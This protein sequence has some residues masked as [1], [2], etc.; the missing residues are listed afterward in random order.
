MINDNIASSLE[1]TILYRPAIFSYN[2]FKR[3]ELPFKKFYYNLRYSEGGFNKIN[4][5]EKNLDSFYLN[6]PDS[7]PS[8]YRRM[9]GE[10]E[11][12]VMNVLASEIDEDT[13]YWEFGGAWGY[14][15]MAI[16][17]NV[18]ECYSFEAMEERVSKINKSI[19]KN[20]YEHVETI[21]GIVGE[22]VKL[23]Q[24]PTPDILLMDV[25]GF[26]YKILNENSWLLEN[27]TTFIIEVHTEEGYVQSAGETPNLNPEGVIE[28]LKNNDYEISQID[29]G[30]NYHIKAKPE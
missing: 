8:R 12:K 25:E 19:E 29:N 27:S 28:I 13:I 7:G 5:P 30:K 24:Y 15:S 6:L 10:W 16:A 22:D 14:F 4:V 18:K 23:T 3:L 20:K 11:P 9:F 1:E 26:E 21:C 2:V 17:S